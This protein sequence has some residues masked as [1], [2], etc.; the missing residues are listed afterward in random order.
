MLNFL[1]MKVQQTLAITYSQ[2]SMEKVRYSE[3]YV[4]ARELCSR[5]VMR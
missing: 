5:C 3:G 2:G 4:I 1:V